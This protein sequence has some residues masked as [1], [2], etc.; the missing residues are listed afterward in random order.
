[1]TRPSLKPEGTARQFML[2]M[3]AKSVITSPSGGH[4]LGGPG[5]Y[6]IRGL[7]WS[8]RGSIRR[9]EVSV[10]GGKTWRDAKLQTPVLRLAHTRFR[11]DWRWDGR[12]ALLQTRCTDDTRYVQPTL[13]ELGKVRGLNSIS[14]NN[15][16]QSSE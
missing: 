16:N 2:V 14:Q 3:E 15:A 10:D 8:G 1:P 13:A 9:V 12:E 7:A 6:E 4:R 5:F 11:F